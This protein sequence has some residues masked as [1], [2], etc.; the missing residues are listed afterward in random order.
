MNINFSQE[1]ALKQNLS[2]NQNLIQTLNI[3][4]LPTSDLESFIN[5]ESEKNPFLEVSYPSFNNTTTRHTTLSSQELSDKHEAVI[6]NYSNDRED[7]FSHLKS[8]LG[9]F[10][11]NDDEKEIA[12]LIISSLDDKGL[13]NS[14]KNTLLQNINIDNKEEIFDK[15][16]NLIMHLD[17][18]GV[19]T[20]NIWTAL[21]VQLDEKQK[22]GEITNEDYSLCLKFLS[23]DTF[24]FLNIDE[25]KKLSS[26]DEKAKK[27]RDI[28]RTLNPYPSF[29]FKTNDDAYIKP[30][31]F[32]EKNADGTISVHTD[33]DALPSLSL[34]NEYVN[35]LE[36]TDDKD[37]RKYLRENY[38][39]ALNLIKA[40]NERNT[41]LLLIGNALLKKQYEFF[42]KGKDYIK[43]LT[44]EDISI[45]VKRDK[46][47][48]SRII[49]SKYMDTPYGVFMLKL[50]FQKS[51]A[52][53]TNKTHSENSSENNSN[54][55]SREKA[56]SILL[57]II[58]ENK[59]KKISDEKLSLLLRNEGIY[60]SRRT[61]NKYRNELEASIKG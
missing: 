19:G 45:D 23:K 4:T 34:D 22:N 33:N 31:L 28:I 29:G 16:Q 35:L 7:L 58:N 26:F 21:K 55:I 52:S 13:L 5:S 61:V 10:K 36:N 57:K 32:F 48:I 6:N 3:I 50:L 14:D 9:L 47:T 60:I 27:A 44:L 37:T 15:M 30:E 49:N 42:E 8:Q 41:T 53:Y 25:N 56:K 51:I 17:P 20:N 11:L 24:E 12:L 40:L 39:A 54:N 1:Q 46:S 59:G 38:T 18:L 2:L 43:P